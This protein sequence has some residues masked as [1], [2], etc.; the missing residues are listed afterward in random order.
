MS[1][2]ALRSLLTPSPERSA[3]IAGSGVERPLPGSSREIVETPYGSAVVFRADESGPIFLSRH[4]VQHDIPPH[5]IN[6]RANMAALRL[7]GVTRVLSTF[8]VG[9][10]ALDIA[11]G[12]IVLVDQLID[13][14]S[15]RESTFFDGGE[16]GVEHV[17][18]SE[19]FCRGLGAAVLLRAAERGARVRAGG[20]Y[21]CTNGPRLESAAEI[22]MYAAL[23]AHVVG[24]TAAPEAALAREAG[25]HYAGLA[26][27]VNWAAGVH[28]PIVIDRQAQASARST[29][30]PLLLD[31]LAA[32]TPPA[33]GCA[34]LE[35]GGR[36]TAVTG[37]AVSPT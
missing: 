34:F 18:F 31:A 4:G 27:S 25:L 21:V 28:G 26:V 9:S 37:Q 11:P 14:T 10:I 17:D 7:L 36:P 19:P 3:V 5:R 20:T 32:S 29:L 23:G 8:T 13:Q 22:R 6:Y 12:D 24:M 30:L 16:T 35:R 1:T 15:G 33:C 2:D